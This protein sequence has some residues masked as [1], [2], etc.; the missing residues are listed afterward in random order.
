MHITKTTIIHIIMPTSM[1][2]TMVHIT[3]RIIKHNIL[4]YA[5]YYAHNCYEYSY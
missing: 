3:M 4:H 5:D 2:I 1:H